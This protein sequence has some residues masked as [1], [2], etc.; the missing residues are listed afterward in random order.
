MGYLLVFL[1]ILFIGICIDIYVSFY[2]KQ[3]IIKGGED[4]VKSIISFIHDFLNW[5]ILV[6]SV[7]SGFNCKIFI[8]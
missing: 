3:K 2:K 6:I 1:N 5:W 8:K 7:I 4:N